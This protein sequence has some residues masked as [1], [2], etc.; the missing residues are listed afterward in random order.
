MR[1]IRRMLPLLLTLGI[2]LVILVPSVAGA[3]T[4][5][6]ACVEPVATSFRTPSGGIDTAAYLA[7]VSAYNAC[8]AGANTTAATVVPAKSL[9][10][11]G[12]NSTELAA[13]ALAVVGLGAGAI[14]VSK[15]RAGAT[16]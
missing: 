3:Q 16:S 4:S 15:R 13:I 2:G 9:A 10:F 1:Q 6:A 8:V 7:A 14:L 11:T 12:S 5:K